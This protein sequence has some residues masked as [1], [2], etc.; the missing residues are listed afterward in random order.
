MFE[1]TQGPWSF[2]RPWATEDWNCMGWKCP[3]G[4][5]YEQ[6][7]HAAWR[8]AVL[9][10]I[11]FIFWARRGGVESLIN[12][13]HEVSFKARFRDMRL[14]TPVRK[15][16]L[17]QKRC[18]RGRKLVVQPFNTAWRRQTFFVSSAVTRKSEYFGERDD[19]SSF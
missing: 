18:G 19:R 3:S 4:D 7:E 15:P 2:F 11:E 5:T 16:N 13:I 10:T 14:F 17:L 12:M 9:D 6:E 8:E 1:N